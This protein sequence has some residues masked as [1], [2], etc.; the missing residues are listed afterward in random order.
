ME[1]SFNCTSEQHTTSLAQPQCSCYAVPTAHTKTINTAQFCIAELLTDELATASS[2]WPWLFK[3]RRSAGQG[4]L[5]Q[6]NEIHAWRI[7]AGQP[8]QRAFVSSSP[9]VCNQT[10]SMH[11]ESRLAS[12]R[13]GH[14]CHHHQ[15]CATKR[16]PC[17]E[18]QGWPAHAKGIC[19]IITSCVHMDARVTTSCVVRRKSLTTH[20]LINVTNTATTT[21]TKAPKRWSPSSNRRLATVASWA[22]SRRRSRVIVSDKTAPPHSHTLLAPLPP[23]D[24]R[25]VCKKFTSSGRQATTQ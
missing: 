9:V 10:R 19:V 18:N 13:K 7:K 8:T 23:W 2:C 22:W 21:T 20:E 6:P 15:L 5:P 17:M 25:D 11:G 4:R 1:E 12:P 16:D 24:G 14:L 3:A